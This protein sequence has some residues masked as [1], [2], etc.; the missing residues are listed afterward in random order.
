MVFLDT[1][2]WIELCSV[3]TPV[4]PNEI[5]QANEAGRLLT[6]LLNT[7]EEIVTFNEQLLE[8]VSAVQKVKMREY[9]NLCKGGTIKG[10]G[11]LKEFRGTCDYSITKNLCI[12]VC[13]DVCHFAKL[14]NIGEIKVKDILSRI[15]IADIND[16]MYYDYCRENNIKL[17]TF[18][19]DYRLIDAENIVNVI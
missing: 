1:C 8:I 18:D 19:T 17:Y 12:Q 11:N 15:D 7:K 10:V 4:K 9:N 2:I 13:E 5:R 16:C 6:N 3:R 14:H